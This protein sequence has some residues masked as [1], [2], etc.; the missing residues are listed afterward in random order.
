MTE[1]VA[2]TQDEGTFAIV[3]VP[4]DQAQAVID[5]V[6]GLRSKDADVSGHLLGGLLTPAYHL[7]TNTNCTHVTTTLDDGGKKTDI[8]CSDPVTD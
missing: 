8:T 5:F 4:S 6:A 3:T 2:S 1:D 7:A